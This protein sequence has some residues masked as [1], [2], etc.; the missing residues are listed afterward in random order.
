MTKKKTEK[1][2][3]SRSYQLTINN[4]KK[5]NITRDILRNLVKKCN[6]IYFCISEEIG[7][8]EHTE[9]YHCY[10]KMQNGLRLST[11]KRKLNN[12][13]FHIEVA[14][15]T[16]KDNRDYLM[17]TGK[18]EEEKGETLIDFEEWGELP[19]D[20]KTKK[21][22]LYNQLLDNIKIGKTTMEI[23]EENPQLSMKI[24]Y[25]NQLRQ[26]YLKEKFS[27]NIKTDLKIC[28]LWGPAGVGKSRSIIETFGMENCC[29]VTNYHTNRGANFDSY[30]NQSVLVLEDY[31]SQLNIYDLLGI[32]DIYVNFLPRRYTDALNSS[33][34]IYIVSNL[35][36]DF[37][38][39]EYR[40]NLHFSKIIQA[41]ER[42]VDNILEMKTDGTI[43]AH[44]LTKK[45]ELL[46]GKES[47]QKTDE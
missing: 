22:N 20:S 34:R 40:G 14:N 17:K 39:S 46:D 43:I 41:L 15:G 7:T 29:R 27:K 37:Q 45:E 33:N 16:A 19:L 4:P 47:K 6:P 36:W 21:Q 38:Y 12:K 26:T 5:H 10:F 32:C 30:E 11:L 28:Y 2:I 31:A 3:Q 25:I 35:P 44:K 24:S 1:D 8:K 18:W 23:I 42:R 9:H 13:A